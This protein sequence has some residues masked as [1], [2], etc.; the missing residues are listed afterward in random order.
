MY[1]KTLHFL[2][3]EN[4]CRSQMAE[5]WG[6]HYLGTGW[7]VISAGIKTSAIDPMTIEVMNEIGIDISKQISKMMD[8]SLLKESDFVITLSREADRKCPRM[9]PYVTKVHWGFD[10]PATTRRS[11]EEKREA[12]QRV[13]DEIGAR[14]KQFA[15]TGK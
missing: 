8:P 5:G 12:F 10:D 2:G 3:N 14:I 1:Q 15:E 13:R 11:G 7:R 6:K 9:Q 4:A